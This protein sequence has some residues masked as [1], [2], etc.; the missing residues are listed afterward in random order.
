MN[1]SA[2][3]GSG[4][5][6]FTLMQAAL[7]GTAAEHHQQVL[8]AFRFSTSPSAASSEAPALGDACLDAGGLSAIGAHLRAALLHLPTPRLALLVEPLLLPDARVLD[9]LAP[10]ATTEL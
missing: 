2:F 1:T 7:T 5:T 4:C 6:L 10:A 8:S 3:S 9:V